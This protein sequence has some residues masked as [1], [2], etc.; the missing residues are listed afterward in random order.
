MRY[1]FII[2]FSFNMANAEVPL[3]EYSKKGKASKVKELIKAGA[4]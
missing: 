3:I 2:F 4:M 1:L